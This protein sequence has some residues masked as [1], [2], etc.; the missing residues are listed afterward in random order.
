MNKSNNIFKYLVIACGALVIFCGLSGIALPPAA[1]DVIVPLV[2][3]APPDDNEV[4]T[5]VS[6]KIA[7]GM[8]NYYCIFI[9]LGVVIVASSCA[10][11]RRNNF[12]TT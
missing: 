8:R 9:V 4:Y 1:A 10:G 6:Q 12:P 7:Q 2:R 5:L 3:T 11:L